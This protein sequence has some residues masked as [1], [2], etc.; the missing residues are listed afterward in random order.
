V[1]APATLLARVHELRRKIRH[2]EEQYYIHSAPE[3]SDEA[4]DRLLH[5]L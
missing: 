5:E 4:F 1:K 2:H 3:V